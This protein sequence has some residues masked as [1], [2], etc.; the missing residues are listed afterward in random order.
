LEERRRWQEYFE[1]LVN[2]PALEAEYPA[3]AETLCGMVDVL[4]ETMCSK[5]P[6]IRVGGEDKPREV[7]AGQLMKL[8]YEHLEYVLRCLQE[9]SQ[10]VKNMW[11]YLLT[12][13]Y[14]APSTMAAARYTSGGSRG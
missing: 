10:P 1:D 3:D 9:S 2:L 7:V 8:Q 6:E 5:E 13:L 14:K 12:A 4:V 11:Q